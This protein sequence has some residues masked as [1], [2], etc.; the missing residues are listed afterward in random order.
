M[1]AGHDRTVKLWNPHKSSPQPD[2]VGGAVGKPRKRG[3]VKQ[4]LLI[5]SYDGVHSHAV[6]DLTMYVG[7]PRFAPREALLTHGS[8]CCSAHDNAKF[9]SC[10]GD[11]SAFLWDV[12]TGKMIRKFYGHEGVGPFAALG[13]TWPFV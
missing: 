6:H 5:K 2:A 12:A 4:A 10:G 1:T 7:A 9:A 11:K 3:A 13:W 8:C